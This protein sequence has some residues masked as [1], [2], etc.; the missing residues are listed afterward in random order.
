MRLVT[1]RLPIRTISEVEVCLESK[2]RANQIAMR[3]ATRAGLRWSI[4]LTQARLCRA[5]RDIQRAFRD[6][7]GR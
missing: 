7:I 6:G 3:T 4:A 2:M 5:L 1:L